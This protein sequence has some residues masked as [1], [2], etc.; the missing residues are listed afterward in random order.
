MSETV[1]FTFEEWELINSLPIEV[2][3]AASVSDA[4]DGSGSTRE[5]MTAINAF[6]TGAMLL[7]HNEIVRALFEEYK[8][9]GRGEERLLQLSQDPPIDLV[10]QTI[11]KATA[12][13]GILAA[14]GDQIEA[15]EYRNW[16]SSL[17]AEIVFSSKAG[18]FLGIGGTRVTDGEHSFLTVLNDAL[19]IALPPP[20]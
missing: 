3:A 13:T 15:E 20:E 1:G 19:G 6:P 2:A 5:I 9:D 12:V 7:R 16:L 17:A 10:N 8:T 18:G 11:E 4:V 14:R